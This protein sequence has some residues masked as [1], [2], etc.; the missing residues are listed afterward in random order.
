MYLAALRTRAGW[1]QVQAAQILKVSQSAVTLWETGRMVPRKGKIP[2][3]AEAY[4][5]TVE[6]VL[7]AIRKDKEEVSA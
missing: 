4:G 7:D 1:S 3:I 6:A 5:T 2:L